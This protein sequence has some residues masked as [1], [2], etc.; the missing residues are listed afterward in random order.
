MNADI[1]YFSSGRYVSRNQLVPQSRFRTQLCRGIIE[2]EIVA[3]S[4]E[5]FCNIYTY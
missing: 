4:T 2:G 1:S 5:D 3:L